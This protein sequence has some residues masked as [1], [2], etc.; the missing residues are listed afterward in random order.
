MD[1]KETK[2]QRKP[3]PKDNHVCVYVHITYKH[4]VQISFNASS[5][6]LMQDR[7]VQC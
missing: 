1:T 2:T 7:V 5:T 6:K 4:N 3:K